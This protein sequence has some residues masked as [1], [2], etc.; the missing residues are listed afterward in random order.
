MKDYF[1]RCTQSDKPELY[2][3]AEALGQVLLNPE[4]GTY[5]GPGW[6]DI[7]PIYRG[8]GEFVT[9]D[10]VETELTAPVLAPDGQPYHHANLRTSDDLRALAEAAG[11]PVVDLGR[12]FVVDE[13]GNPTTP[14]QPAVVFA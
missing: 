9:V 13:E 7:G 11:I 5:S 8:T 6:V 4:T 12:F 10:G 2:R 1:I 3:L 14:K